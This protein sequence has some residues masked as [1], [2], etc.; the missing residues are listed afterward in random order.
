[1]QEAIESLTKI[2]LQILDYDN[3]NVFFSPDGEMGF[4]GWKKMTHF[5]EGPGGPLSEKGPTFPN[6]M[7]IGGGF[8]KKNTCFHPRFFLGRCSPIWL[9]HMDF[10]WVGSK[11]QPTSFQIPWAGS[12]AKIPWRKFH[13]LREGLWGVNFRPMTNADLKLKNDISRWANTESFYIY[14]FLLE[15]RVEREPCWCC[16]LKMIKLTEICVKRFLYN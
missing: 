4:C 8:E 6:S 15:K 16:L 12:P 3:L 11:T 1:M 13:D 5:F 9:E 2:V 7:P 10:Q 14:I